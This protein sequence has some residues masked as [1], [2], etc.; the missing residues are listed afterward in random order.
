MTIST[1]G[2]IA[3]PIASSVQPMVPVTPYPSSTISI[4]K[5]V[6]TSMVSFRPVHPAV[7][8]VQPARFVVPVLSAQPPVTMFRYQPMYI[9]PMATSVVIPVF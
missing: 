3:V 8:I 2:T 4:V 6:N 9:A 1:S 7:N 5:P